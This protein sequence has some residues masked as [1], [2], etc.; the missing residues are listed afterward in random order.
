MCGT[1]GCT[2]ADFHSGPCSFELS[3]G[4]RSSAARTPGL[5]AAVEKGLASS[6]AGVKRGPAS[7]KAKD[8]DEEPDA[9]R[10]KA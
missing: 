1:P 2:F 9:K 4:K 3:L 8:N 7:S 6:E 10:R 5:L